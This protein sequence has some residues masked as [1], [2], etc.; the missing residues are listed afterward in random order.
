MFLVMQLPLMNPFTAP[1]WIA[2]VWALIRSRRYAGIGFA[3]LILVTLEIVLHGKIYYTAPVYPALIAAGAVALESLTRSRRMW[4]IAAPVAI[5]AG[6]LAIMPEA[7]PALPL[8]ALLVY[9]HAIDVRSVKIEHTPTGMLPQQ[10]ADQLGWNDL[11]SSVAAVVDSLSPQERADAVILTHDYGQASALDF[12]GRR[13][14]LPPAISGH[15]QFYLWGPYGNHRVIVAIGIPKS[16]LAREFRTI[17][18][19]GLYVSPYVLPENNHLPI[20]VCRDPRIPFAAFWPRLR[21]YV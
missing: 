20:Y 11:E 5:A 10:F 3:Y 1:L 13:D 6:A 17:V 16:L 8:P 18:Q 12:L 9:Q 15:N 2:G 21:S 4:R 7:T 19:A 14:N